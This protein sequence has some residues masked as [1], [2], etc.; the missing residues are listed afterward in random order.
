MQTQLLTMAFSN[1]SHEDL[2]AYVSDLVA[3]VKRG[4]RDN[5]LVY[6][7]RL[8]KSVEAYTRTTPPHVKAARLL[9]HAEGVIRYLMTVKGPQPIGYVTAAIDYPHYIQKQIT[10]IAKTIG[11]VVG[12][13]FVAALT[14]EQWLFK[15]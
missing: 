5:D 6:R 11:D 2:D 9:P 8:R 10:P 1:A 7:K 3:T 13:D 14:G 15:L 12:V 4:E